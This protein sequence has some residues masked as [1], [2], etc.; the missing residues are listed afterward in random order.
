MEIS[1]RDAKMMYENSILMLG[2]DMVYVSN[3][4]EDEVTIF[5]IQDKAKKVFPCKGIYPFKPIPFR[6][7]YC[8]MGKV[9]LYMA[10]CAQRQWKV[11][12]SKHN[13][14]FKVPLIKTNPYSEEILSS[15][16]STFPF[17]RGMETFRHGVYPTLEEAKELLCED[18]HS[19]AI[20]RQF[21]ITANNEVWFKGKRVGYWSDKGIKFRSNYEYLHSVMGVGYAVA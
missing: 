21:A 9:A 16:A 11:G 2:D 17:F 5:G 15:I 13:L 20:D 12:L 18:Y 8:Q 3:V 10:R 14:V 1:V 4:G 7:G 19:V 6:L